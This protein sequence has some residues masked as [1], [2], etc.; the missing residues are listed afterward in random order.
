MCWW[1]LRKSCWKLCKSL[2]KYMVHVPLFNISNLFW[3]LYC[4]TFLNNIQCSFYKMLHIQ[5]TCLSYSNSWNSDRF[6]WAGHIEKIV[7]TYMCYGPGHIL[8]TKTQ[9]WSSLSWIMAVEW[10][11]PMLAKA[12]WNQLGTAYT[13][14]QMDLIKYA[15]WSRPNRMTYRCDQP[16]LHKVSPF[17]LHL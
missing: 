9:L 14:N 4:A 10:K 8:G 3:S 6:T 15:S 2:H 1:P 12:S 13:V 11:E 7:Q 5:I 17:C 16:L